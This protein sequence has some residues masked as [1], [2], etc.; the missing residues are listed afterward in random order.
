MCLFL[1]RLKSRAQ[2]SEQLLM[3]KSTLADK[4]LSTFSQLTFLL[5]VAFG[6]LTLLTLLETPSKSFTMSS[7]VAAATRAPASVVSET[8]TAVRPTI[9]T[10]K[11]NCL[12]SQ[13]VKTTA[14]HA[15]ISVEGCLSQGEIRV[16]NK[17]R[18][19]QSTIFR[20]NGKV[21]T[22][23]MG[24]ERGENEVV[25][26]QVLEGKSSTVRHLIVRE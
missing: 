18:N 7:P 17:T 26:Q 15:R 25:F 2:S 14:E 19:I 23:Y 20:H 12:S 9:T 24:L 8:L 10:L 11:L 6:G 4:A 13:K 21:F 5:V 1:T 3:S 22:D 16:E